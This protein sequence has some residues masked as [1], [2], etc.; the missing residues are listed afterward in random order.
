MDRLIRMAGDRALLITPPPEQV[1][2][3]VAALRARRIDGI[4]DLLPA[5]ET[6]FVTLTSA[7]AVERVHR[8]LDE[9]LRR[10]ADFDD[11]SRGTPLVEQPDPVRIPVH[12]DGAD[13]AE[14]AR[15]LDMSVAEVIAAHT[16]TVWRCAFVGFAPG[17]GY[18]E[19]DGR[20][21]VPRRAE[22]RTAIPAGAVAVA[23]GYSAVY[24]RATPGGW[25]LI[26]HTDLR[27]WDVDRD[28]P[29]LIRAGAVVAF[30]DAGRAR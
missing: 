4:M 5:A 26:G 30:V 29:A 7:A 24:P 15:L 11:V 28:P 8:E 3:V 2:A 22:P 16:G 27:M 19:S 14:V 20:L 25:Q 17:F 6:V 10:V 18:L 1:P 23:G 21:A 12:Y 13:L 9:L